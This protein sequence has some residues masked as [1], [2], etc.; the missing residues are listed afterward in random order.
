ME[1]LYERIRKTEVIPNAYEKW[2]EY[3]SGLTNYI[4]ERIGRDKKVA[5]LGAGACNDIELPPLLQAGHEITLLDC[6]EKAMEEGS[7]RQFSNVADRERVFRKKIDVWDVTVQEYHELE[8]LLFQRKPM[9]TVLEHMQKVMERI[10][11]QPVEELAEMVQRQ[12][13]VVCVGFHSQ[14]TVMFITLLQYYMSFY[15]VGYT[16]DE[17][18]EDQK[19]I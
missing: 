12:D 11:S 14:V 9:Q 13:V 7:I 3:R 8:A 15:N 18:D 5:I 16:K 6:D 19:L 2:T 10:V 1:Y 4:L 17:V